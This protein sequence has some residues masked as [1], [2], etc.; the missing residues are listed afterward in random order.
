MISADEEE[1]KKSGTPLFSSHMIDLSE[2]D[3][4]YNIDTTA[5]Y[6]KRSAPVRTSCTL[7]TVSATNTWHR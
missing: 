5:A 4:K 1:F 2:D 3:V 7:A 6:L